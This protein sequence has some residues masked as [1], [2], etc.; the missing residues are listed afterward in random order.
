MPSISCPC[1]YSLTVDDGE[2]VRCPECL[3][4]CD[5][6]APTE[7]DGEDVATDPEHN[8][9]PRGNG[10]KVAGIVAGAVLLAVLA[11]VAGRASVGP[12]GERSSIW[13]FGSSA[14]SG[15]AVQVTLAQLCNDHAQNLAK[16]ELEYAGKV[17]EFEAKGKLERGAGGR[18][19]FLTAKGRL[20][21]Q[22]TASAILRPEQVHNHMAQAAL[23][24]EYVPNYYLYVSPAGL[25]D[26]AD[27]PADRP[28]R[29]RGKY[30][31]AERD[32][33]TIPEFAFTLEDC[34]LVG[35]R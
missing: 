32:E 15:P 10:L 30:K 35:G 6:S 12:G 18:Y 8:P 23:N 20:V 22:K 13:P 1:G 11:F 4:L 29:I 17:L 3:R 5:T 34:E 27:V 19:Y 24:A 21:K 14:L 7:P 33:R 31:G 9:A 2:S 16:A 28:V 25:K 26:L